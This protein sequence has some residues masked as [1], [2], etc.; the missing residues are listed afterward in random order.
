M[1]MVLK[2][3]LLPCKCIEL[4]LNSALKLIKNSSQMALAARVQKFNLELIPSLFCWFS[5]TI[6]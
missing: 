3:H 2:N 6:S 4:R 1:R 5:V